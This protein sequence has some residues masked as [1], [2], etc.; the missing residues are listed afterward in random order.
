M[1][2]QATCPECRTPLFRSE[3]GAICPACTL[4]MG[5]VSTAP[6]TVAGAGVGDMVGPWQLDA[7]IREGPMARVFRA[8]EVGSKQVV[9]VKLLST[10]L[11]HDEVAKHRFAL[12]ASRRLHHPHLV[13][14]LDSGMHQGCPYLV[15]E[16]QPGGSLGDWIGCRWSSPSGKSTL[17]AED[18]RQAASWVRQTAAAVDH[19]HQQGLIHRDI[20]PSNVLLDAEGNAR[21]GD[22]GISTDLRN[23]V[24]ATPT[25]A[26]LGSPAYMAPELVEGRT[27]EGTASGDIYGLGAILLELLTGAPPHRG[28]N[29]LSTLRQVSLESTPS[30]RDRNPDV[31]RDLDIICRH[32]LARD[33]K[34]RYRSA[35]EVEAE[36]ERFL[37]G[38]PL[39]ASAPSALGQ[40]RDWA[41]QN[42]PSAIWAAIAIASL[43]MGLIGTV[44]ALN[45]V[46]T[47]LKFNQDLAESHRKELVR[48]WANRGSQALA[49]GR[50][51]EAL[52]W[53]FSA[54][55]SDKNAGCPQ[56]RQELHQTRFGLA[57]SILPEL[58]QWVEAPEDSTVLWHAPHSSWAL[59]AGRNR[60]LARWR[61][62]TGAFA[63]CLQSRLPRT[64]LRFASAGS[65]D[66][67]LA[68]TSG[69]NQT[70][71]I[72][73]LHCAEGR[74]MD[75]FQVPGLLRDISLSPDRKWLAISLSGS[76]GIVEVWDW[77]L[78]KNA[79]G[80][81]KHGDRV[82]RIAWLPD[83]RLA[84][85]S[86][87]GWVR[88]WD[89]KSGEQ[90][91]RWQSDE[92]IRELVVDPSGRWL[93]FGGDDRLVTLVNLQDN[94]ILAQL[95][96]PNW[97]A[98]LAV[99]P[100]GNALVSADRSGNIR[101]W[102]APSGV[103][104]S[105]WIDCGRSPLRSLSFSPGGDRFVIQCDDRS[106][107]IFNV[108]PIPHRCATLVGAHWQS[109]PVWD[110]DRTLIVNTRSGFFGLWRCRD[111]GPLENSI[112][113]A[114]NLKAAIPSPDD[115]WILVGGENSIHLHAAS[116]GKQSELETTFPISGPADRLRFYRSSSRFLAATRKGEVL[117]GTA[118]HPEPPPLR[119][120]R[121]KPLLD[122]D[123]GAT[124]SQILIAAAS[125][126]LE[127]WK[128]SLDGTPPRL[129]QSVGFPPLKDGQLE[130]SPNGRFVALAV[131]PSDRVGQGVHETR[132]LH[133]WR[134]PAL[135]AVDLR[136][137]VPAN[138]VSL[139]FSQDE[140][141]LAAGGGD[142][143]IRVFQTSNGRQVGPILHHSDLI[144]SM[145]FSRRGDRLF[146]GG[147]DRTIGIWDIP[148]GQRLLPDLALSASVQTVAISSNGLLIAA[149]TD[150]SIRVWDSD[151][152]DVILA[153]SPPSIPIRSAHLSKSGDFVVLGCN[154]KQ[155]RLTRLRAKSLPFEQARLWA[156]LL[157]PQIPQEHAAPTTIPR[158][159]LMETWNQLQHR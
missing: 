53:F 112:R 31:P 81:L 9:V 147:P 66:E 82:S 21:L 123:F 128:L 92:Y 64:I 1:S 134:L 60:T 3:V 36:L 137:E 58:A 35:F 38:E 85:A 141:L 22:L 159:Q 6:L 124:E 152:L 104:L 110:D 68:L 105:D 129:D 138:M 62:D 101:V 46:E 23:E 20:K 16:F 158:E 125:G 119:L 26:V 145:T 120:Q 79:S 63:M 115:R 91:A 7:L 69:A 52:G 55:R 37:N 133:L 25:G 12:E 39:K 70:F 17:I 139:A 116:S 135:A 14:V 42:R 27:M 97:I 18:F 117:V 121:E 136:L 132:G 90:L 34:K 32:C 41:R 59:A 57:L 8:S 106:V 65:P 144:R 131:T 77:G 99:S 102:N 113:S 75:S 11:L 45:R 149:A 67:V 96:H 5:L 47:A 83:G 88:L 71:F 56:E 28:D 157:A 153:H 29:V 76:Q 49:D 100:D 122:A 150:A 108:H 148:S 4:R 98:R 48:Q 140:T 84:T 94:R 118:T 155:V 73:R 111:N 13:P 15:A 107:Q 126:Q 146:A 43:I 89:W 130:V 19:L 2:T 80:G 30:P 10:Q 156:E 44:S 54:W 33:P 143:Q 24:H 74:V 78:K 154:D 151:T 51:D 103:P 95:P 93:A 142:G 86:W 50:P 40:L 114:F 72:D 109:N 127:S 87:D 61:V